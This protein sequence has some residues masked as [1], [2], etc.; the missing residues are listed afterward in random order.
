M[1]AT[2]ALIGQQPGKGELSA[3]DQ[4]KK[5]WGMLWHG[6]NPHQHKRQCGDT[7][8][9]SEHMGSTSQEYGCTGDCDIHTRPLWNPLQ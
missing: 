5:L 3:I 7:H 6:W 8:R 2:F 4:N 1:E 9:L